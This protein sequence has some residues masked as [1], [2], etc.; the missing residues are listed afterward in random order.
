M[1]ASSQNHKLED[2][3]GSFLKFRAWLIDNLI[4]L[5][6]HLLHH[7][8]LLSAPFIVNWPIAN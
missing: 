6:I 3:K 1:V 7:L 4:P 8:L 5:I 2:K